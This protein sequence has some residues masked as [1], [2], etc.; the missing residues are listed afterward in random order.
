MTFLILYLLHFAFDPALKIG[1]RDID[2]DIYLVTR[3]ELLPPFLVH[4]CFTEFILRYLEWL[5]EMESAI[6]IEQA[7]NS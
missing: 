7:D 5:S 2:L 3:F 1:L 6:R 4:V